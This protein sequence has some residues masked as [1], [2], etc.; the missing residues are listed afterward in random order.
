MEA[1]F[2]RQALSCKCP[3]CGEGALYPRGLNPVLYSS[4]PVCGLHLGKNDSADGPAVFLI[5]VL[6]F[7]LV[8]LALLLEAAFSPPLWFHGVLWGAVALILTLGLLRPVKSLVIALQY[9]HR[10]KDWE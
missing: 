2:W 5:F 9:R 8:P 3:R 4:C 10:P 7:A 1:A 6:G